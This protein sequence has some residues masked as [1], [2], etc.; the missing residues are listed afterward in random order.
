MGMYA[1]PLAA[2]I[3]S[4]AA[5]L[6]LALGIRLVMPSTGYRQCIT[7]YGPDGLPVN[8]W[9]HVYGAKIDGQNGW[10]SFAHQGKTVYLGSTSV[11]EVFVPKLNEDAAMEVP[12]GSQVTLQIDDVVVRRWRSTTPGEPRTLRF[13]GARQNEGTC[14]TCVVSFTEFDSNH[15]IT[16]L[17][18][19][20]E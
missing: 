18:Y 11:V 5:L 9:S 2:V 19:L 3:L 14:I 8:L 20:D 17:G 10:L 16:I 6:L 13:R 4:L 7:N 12:Y 1:L 15:R